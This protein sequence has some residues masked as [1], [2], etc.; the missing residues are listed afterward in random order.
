MQHRRDRCDP[1]LMASTLWSSR[2]EY[3]R[4]QKPAGTDEPTRPCDL[5]MERDIWLSVM[6]GYGLEQIFEP[7]YSATVVLS[8]VL[9]AT[10]S[11]AKLTG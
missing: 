1:V 6:D 4:A 11:R 10:H 2:I 3:R 5:S 7:L 8:A 9:L